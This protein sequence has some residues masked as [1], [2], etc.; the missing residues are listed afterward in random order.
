M[1]SVRPLWLQMHLS[2][3]NLDNSLNNMPHP[4]HNWKEKIFW[5]DNEIIREVVEAKLLELI[6]KKKGIWWSAEMNIW[7]A[8]VL[9]HAKLKISIT[10]HNQI[11]L[12][13][14][15]IRHKTKYEHFM[16]Q[17]TLKANFF[18]GLTIPAEKRFPKTD[19][20][21]VCSTYSYFAEID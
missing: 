10:T 5:M 4:S 20:E 21:G 14:P 11:K 13:P 19:P 17:I 1:E 2:N 8:C 6:I 7:K 16:L 15:C 18:E 12:T 9:V 3:T